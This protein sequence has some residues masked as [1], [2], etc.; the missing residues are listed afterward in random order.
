MAG[1]LP[2]FLMVQVPVTSGGHR[3][4]LELTSGWVQQEGVQGA[5]RS[6]RQNGVRCRGG[7]V[8]YLFMCLSL[9]VDKGWRV[10]RVAEVLLFVR[11]VAGR[12]RLMVFLVAGQ[13][14]QAAPLVP[15]MTPHA[16]K[17]VA[18]VVEGEG[19][20]SPT[21]SPCLPLRP[22]S[23]VWSSGPPKP[24]LSPHPNIDN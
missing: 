23:P 20:G 3:R 24:S 19:A 2:A 13:R 4:C 12:V 9:D 11:G 1:L 15:G 22:P 21:R 5:L 17:A 6:E 18:G 10:L 16:G 14:S 7:N 8:R